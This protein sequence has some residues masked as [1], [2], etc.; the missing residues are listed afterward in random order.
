MESSIKASDG[1]CHESEGEHSEGTFVMAEGKCLK[2]RP[3]GEDNPK[4]LP[5]ACGS[6]QSWKN[7][8]PQGKQPICE[9][10]RKK[11]SGSRR[12]CKGIRKHSVLQSK[13]LPTHEE[14][15]EPEEEND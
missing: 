11:A 9:R 12:M 5:S 2:M 7:L 8:F 10:H 1:H 4:R 13:H 6:G 3:G 14:V 15:S